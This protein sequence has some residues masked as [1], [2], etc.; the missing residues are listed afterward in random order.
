M[1]SLLYPMSSSCTGHCE[2]VNYT[3]EGCKHR[4]T[5][6]TQCLAVA[7][8]T[9]SW[10]IKPPQGRL[11]ARGLM[12][13]DGLLALGL[14]HV[15]EVRSHSQHYITMRLERIYSRFGRYTVAARTARMRRQSGP[16]ARTMD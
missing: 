7:L 3:A 13:N 11:I 1:Y 6:C 15:F 8:T 5:G 12:V 4:S 14:R 10:S 9:V 2:L 16:C